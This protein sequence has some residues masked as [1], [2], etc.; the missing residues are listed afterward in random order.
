MSKTK[1]KKAKDGGDQLPSGNVRYRLFIGVS[2][3]GKKMYKSFTAPTLTKA[4]AKA[5]EWKSEHKILTP[6]DPTFHEAA[7]MYL[8]NR[9]NVLSPSTYADYQKR[10]DYIHREFPLFSRRKLSAIS[11]EGVQT[12]INN[13]ATHP[14]TNTAA[15]RRGKPQEKLMSPKTVRNYVMIIEA[16]LRAHGVELQGLKLPQKKKT[17]LSIPENEL[18]TQLLSEVEGTEL[19]VP[20]LLAAFG[21]MRR[22]EICALRM[23]DID[24]ETGVVHVSRSMVMDEDGFWRVKAP[25]TEAGDRYIHFPREVI[26]KIQQKGYVVKCNPDTL[27]KRFIRTLNRHDLPHFRFHDLRHF[28]ASFQIALGIPPEYVMERGGWQT[29]GTMQRYIHALDQQR[30]EMADNVNAA[31]SGLMRG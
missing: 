15:E 16:V 14:I 31:F 5:K 24:F 20:V 6:E 9:K 25:K 18:V 12:I 19:E 26:D 27:T 11:S 17:R 4:Q 28:S 2:A 3:D 10:I 8:A 22:G 1:S 30:R 29:P 13:L 23:E 7:E 21:P